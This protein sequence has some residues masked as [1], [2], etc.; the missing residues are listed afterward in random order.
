MGEVIN[1]AGKEIIADYVTTNEKGQDVSLFQAATMKKT[2]KVIEDTNKYTQGRINNLSD[3]VD[4]LSGDLSNLS[5]DVDDLSGDLSDLSGDV[6][7]LSGNVTSLSGTVTNISNNR[8]KIGTRVQAEEGYDYLH[9]YAYNPLKA[10]SLSWGADY[11]VNTG[12]VSANGQTC[13][14]Y[15]PG[16]RVSYLVSGFS[17]GTWAILI[18][19]LSVL[20]EAWSIDVLLP[21]PNS[22]N[23]MQWKK[24]D[25]TV[26]N[27][28]TDAWVIGSFVYDSLD[29]ITSLNIN[30]E[31]AT[32]AGF[33]KNRFL[34]IMNDCDGVDTT[35]FTNWAIAM[36][37][38]AIFKRLAALEM[39][40]NRLKAIEGFFDSIK[41]TGNSE[42][43]GVVRTTALYTTLRS[44]DPGASYTLS[45]G[46]TQYFNW[47]TFRSTLASA[48][49]SAGYYSVTGTYPIMRVGSGDIE[50]SSGWQHITSDNPY[51]L[52]SYTAQRNQRLKVS[53]YATGSS[54]SLLVCDRYR[55]TV[56]AS[57][58]NI[59]T[60]PTTFTFDVSSGTTYYFCLGSGSSTI[61]MRLYDDY[62]QF[63]SDYAFMDSSYGIHTYSGYVQGSLTVG[64]YVATA[65]YKWAGMGSASGGGEAINTSVITIVPE[66]GSGDYTSK[67]VAFIS[68]TS[69]SA[70]RIIFS[71]PSLPEK[72]ISTSEYYRS[73]SGTI[74]LISVSDSVVSATITPKD[75]L[76]NIGAST[77]EWN[78]GWFKQVYAN[79]VSLGS[80]RALKENIRLFTG[81]A[82][83][84]INNTEV[85]NFNY[86][87]DEK[88][89]TKI[90]FIADDTPE[91]IAG[92]GHDRM[93]IDHCVA[94]LIKAVQELAAK[95]SDLESKIS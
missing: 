47:T 73:M 35:D 94:V 78:E 6:S 49:P 70:L 4:G 21:E 45:L 66:D 63:G 88:K 82:L 74:T 83:Q 59:S 54:R 28:D 93:K 56:Y 55:Q 53:C 34:Q 95:V 58:N 72:T 65:L 14:V 7:T 20:D 29:G 67:Q 23:I 89:E 61:E 90:G 22:S 39:F 2:Q 33:L 17:K 30:N 80:A 81:N 76:Q 10:Y 79:G 91:E 11:Y 87:N 51:S 69:A 31:A 92:E 40:T 1:L 38:D 46:A 3:D 48:Y 27:L 43:K 62:S 24:P 60:S 41:V 57:Q 19:K 52:Y 68:W 86:K 44:D 8:A 36:K 16:K 84:I 12:Y 77:D 15:I 64:S 32:P 42:F 85:V 37:C 18:R 25:G 75:S 9:V 13:P 71:T 26:V 5:D 50:F